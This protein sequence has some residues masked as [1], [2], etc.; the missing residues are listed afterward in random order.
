V[1]ASEKY[2]QS[3]DAISGFILDKIIKAEN[4]YGVGQQVLNNAFKEWFQMNYGNR[5]APKLS[6]L[7]ESMVKK[8]GNQN[9]KT[10]K[11]YNIKIREEEIQDDMNGDIE[12]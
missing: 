8:F 12:N 4:T 6:E 9:V 3:Q 11:W 5:K 2:R 7:M 10:K 1:A